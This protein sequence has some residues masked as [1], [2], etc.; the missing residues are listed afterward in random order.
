[1]TNVI[2]LGGVEGK[3]KTDQQPFYILNFG[4]P[5][6]RSNVFGFEVAQIFTD[7][8]TYNQFRRNGKPGKEMQAT[9]HFARG[10]WDLIEFKF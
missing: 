7:Q 9:L 2:F 4:S 8:D 1:M 10:G 6:S 5:G 3:R